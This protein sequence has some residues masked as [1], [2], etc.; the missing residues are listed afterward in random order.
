MPG[1]LGFG[2]EDGTTEGSEVGESEDLWC[3]NLPWCFF[4]GLPLALGRG[5]GEGPVIG[6][7]PS[8]SEQSIDGEVPLD[9]GESDIFGGTPEPVAFA[10]PPGLPPPLP[11]GYGTPPG[12]PPVPVPGGTLALPLFGKGGLPEI[13]G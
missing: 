5:T 9:G 7:P 4:L 10:T 11:V 2:L 6:A 13:G 12:R 8:E 1:L 3:F